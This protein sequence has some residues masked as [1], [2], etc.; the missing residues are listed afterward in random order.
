MLINYISLLHKY[1]WQFSTFVAHSSGLYITY[2]A[3]H[4]SISSLG[5]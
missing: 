4:H 5:G 2:M 3:I 1:A